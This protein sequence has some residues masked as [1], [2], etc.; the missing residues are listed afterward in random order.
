MNSNLITETKDTI[1]AIELL[2]ELNLVSSKFIR[3]LLGPNPEEEIPKVDLELSIKMFSVYTD[4]TDKQFANAL[5]TLNELEQ[6]KN[7]LVQKYIPRLR[8]P[9]KKYLSTL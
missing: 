7:E 9:I 2:R 5:I 6:V 1:Q 3:D 4:C 8:E